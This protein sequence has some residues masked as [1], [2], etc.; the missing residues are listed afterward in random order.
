MYSNNAHNKSGFKMLVNYQ[1]ITGQSYL[2]WNFGQRMGLSLKLV[3]LFFNSLTFI[4]ILYFTYMGVRDIQHM[5]SNNISFSSHHIL[6]PYIMQISLYICANIINVYVFLLIQ[7]KGKSILIYINDLDID[8][9][10]KIEKK[11]GIKAIVIQLTLTLLLTLI[12]FLCSR[13]FN[14]IQKNILFVF[15]YFIITIYNTSNYLNLLSIMA[16]FC[17]LIQQRLSGLEDEFISL[18]QLPKIFKHLLVIQRHV[19]KLDQIYNKY[20]FILIIFYSFECISNLT[21]LYFDRYNTMFCPIPA[22]FESLISIF[23]FC[24]LSDKIDKAYVSI[25]NKYE[26]LQLKMHDTQL[27]QFNYCLISRLYSLRDDLCF[28]AFNLYPIN[29]K[30]FMSI[31]SMIITFTVILIQTR[32]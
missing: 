20:I 27:G 21:I 10:S 14:D 22:I 24:Y 23:L 2:F 4:A 18:E 6:M 8:I 30:T 12:F 3:L 32:Y 13:L 15:A 11:I 7:F 29:M 19:K 1:R 9:D 26:Q 5:N 17:Y 16:Y 25:I 28:T 31:L